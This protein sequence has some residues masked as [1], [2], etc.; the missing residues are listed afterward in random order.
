MEILAAI[1]WAATTLYIKRVNQ[2]MALNHYQT[3]F[4]QLVFAIPVL[5]A[6]AILFESGQPIIP[7]GAVLGALS[8]Q[9]IVVAFFSYML[10]FWMIHNFAVSRLAAFT[11]L[12]PLFG[13]IFG[14]IILGEPVGCLVWSGLA[15][16]CFGIFLVNR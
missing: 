12:A 13:V 3:L 10:W 14:A 9:I 11:F 5:S 6:G 1:F 2:H 15:L 8:Y 4:A 16:V 7:T